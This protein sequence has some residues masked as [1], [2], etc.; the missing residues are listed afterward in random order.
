MHIKHC[1]RPLH[2]IYRSELDVTGNFFVSLALNHHVGSSL[3]ST[4]TIQKL[5]A[6]FGIEHA[7]QA[8]LRRDLLLL[9]VTLT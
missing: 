5:G 7:L 2:L 3:G 1:L 4:L 9:V 6:Y 8:S